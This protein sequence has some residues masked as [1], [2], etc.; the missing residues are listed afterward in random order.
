MVI[1]LVSATAAWVAIRRIK[2]AR[3]D[4]QLQRQP[5]GTVVD[6]QEGQGAQ[7]WPHLGHCLCSVA[8]APGPL[9]QQLLLAR[10]VRSIASRMNAATDRP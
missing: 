7:Q 5:Y 8:Q 1:P 9:V 2:A 4:V 3:G 10:Y 6:G